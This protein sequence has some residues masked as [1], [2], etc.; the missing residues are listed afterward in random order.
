MSFHNNNNGG[1]DGPVSGGGSVPFISAASEFPRN[2]NSGGGSHTS[3]DIYD[4]NDSV[5][6]IRRFRIWNLFSPRWYITTLWNTVHSTTF[7]SIITLV[8]FWA[9]LFLYITFYFLYIPPLD[10]SKPIFFQ[11]DSGCFKNC[12]VPYAEVQLSHY[13]SPVVFTRGQSYR[14]QVDLTAPESDVNYHQGMFMIKITLFDSKKQIILSS[15]R[16]AILTHRSYPVRLMLT[17]LRSVP[18][19]FG[20]LKEEE[21]L[22]VPLLDDYVDGIKANLG[23]AVNAKIELIGNHRMIHTLLFVATYSI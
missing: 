8:L 17:A 5:S 2:H 7:A 21:H 22:S 14:I 20:L 23:P 19:T 9:S 12:E 15:G 6:T 11:F 16:P 10:L 3:D 4:D 13:K 18:L 1:G